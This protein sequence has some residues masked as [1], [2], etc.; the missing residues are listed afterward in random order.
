MESNLAALRHRFKLIGIFCLLLFFIQQASSQTFVTQPLTATPS[1]GSYYNNSS[2][3]LL[4]GFSFTASPGQSFQAYVISPDATALKTRLSI[5]RNYILTSTPRMSGMFTAANL[6]NRN[7]GELMQSVEY[8]DGLG[9]SIQSVQI[10]GSPLASDQVTPINY[11]PYGREATKYLP[12]TLPGSGTS[13]GSYKTDALTPGAGQSQFYATPPTGVTANSAPSMATIFEPSPLNRVLEQGAS[14]VPWQPG[15]SGLSGSGHTQKIVYSINNAITWAADTINSLQAAL[16]TVTINADQSRTL[17]RSGGTA[18]YDAGQLAVTVSKDENWRSGR[19]GTTEEYKD[20]ESHTVLKRV[21]NFSGNTLQQLSTYYVYDDLGNLAFV[22]PPGCAADAGLPAQTMINNLA[23][24][25]QYDGRNRLVQK[26]IPGKGWD[27]IIYN[28]LDQVVATQDSNQ[29]VLAQWIYTKYDALGRDI[30]TGLY[31]QTTTRPALQSVVNG[32]TILW[33]APVG[34]SAASGGYTSNSWPANA[35]GF[36]KINYYDTY[37]V[38]GLPAAYGSPPGASTMVTGLVT[39][40]IK[41]ILGTTNMLWS[42]LYY[43]DQGRVTQS[44]Q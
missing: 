12:Y 37:T 16:F 42:V 27:Y 35:S 3:V 2:I 25:Y 38:A 39:A 41:N 9:R 8:V 14:G 26:K 43:D 20:N 22:L 19:A 6:L 36:L 34:T 32:Q 1:A 5:N 23:Y 30:I 28:S 29:R 40:S 24:Q 13:D 18:V 31:P 11:D 10:A 17:T 33:E 4:P 44:Y 15:S 7:T 21:Y